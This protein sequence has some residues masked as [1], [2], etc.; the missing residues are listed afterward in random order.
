[1][2]CYVADKVT[3]TQCSIFMCDIIPLLV[4]SFSLVIPMDGGSHELRDQQ[5]RHQGKF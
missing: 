4:I 1:M 2:T 3:F 5:A